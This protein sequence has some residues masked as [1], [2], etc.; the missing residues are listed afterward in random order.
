MRLNDAN[1][2]HVGEE[3]GEMNDYSNFSAF[4]YTWSKGVSLDRQ[5]PPPLHLLS[6]CSC[7]HRHQGNA[8]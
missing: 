4:S 7:Y 1:M 2:L 8:Q 6:N 3:A 5:E